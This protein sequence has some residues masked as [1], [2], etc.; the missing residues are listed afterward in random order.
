MRFVAILVLGASSVGFAG[1]TPTNEKDWHKQID[2][3]VNGTGEDA[4]GNSLRDQHKKVVDACGH[5]LEVKFDWAGFDMKVWTTGYQTPSVCAGNDQLTDLASACTAG[6]AKAKKIK[7]LTCHYKPCA[8]LPDP[9]SGAPGSNLKAT[10]AQYKLTQK[11]T[12]V[13]ETFCE[14]TSNL[15]R[16]AFDVFLKKR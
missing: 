12:N 6:N 9:P 10:E 5:D 15:G 3:Y 16:D 4:S 8:K 2:G 1:G 11:G 13:D 7:T 14:N